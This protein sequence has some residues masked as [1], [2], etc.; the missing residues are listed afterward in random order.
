MLCYVILITGIFPQASSKGASGFQSNESTYPSAV[1]FTSPMTRELC[2]QLQ[3]LQE[4][5]TS[6]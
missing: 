1:V 6:L 2:S 3:E 4:L 5:P